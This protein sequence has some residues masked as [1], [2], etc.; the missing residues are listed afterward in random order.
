LLQIID[1]LDRA[2]ESF[3]ARR[4]PP[5]SRRGKLGLSQTGGD[6]LGRSAA[7]RSKRPSPSVQGLENAQNGKGLAIG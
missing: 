1:R 2:L 6:A 5:S 7:E 4:R 3:M